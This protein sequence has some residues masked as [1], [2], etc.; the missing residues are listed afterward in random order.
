[1]VW[2]GQRSFRPNSKPAQDQHHRRQQYRQ[3]L[4]VHM[5]LETQRRISLSE[6]CDQDRSRHDAEESDGGDDTVATD[7]RVVLRQ[8]SE[9]V[10][11]AVVAHCIEVDAH[12]VGQEEGVAVGVP[13]AVANDEAVA[14]VAAATWIGEAA[15]A[16]GHFDC[17]DGGGGWCFER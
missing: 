16:V 11:H 4:Q 10:A 15:I 5:Q 9:A 8:V 17:V 14:L 13:G 1:M 12:Q 3:N 6:L 2:I 7:E